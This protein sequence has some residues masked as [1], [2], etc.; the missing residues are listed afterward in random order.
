MALESERQALRDNK[1]DREAR[2]ELLSY[3]VR[4]LQ[5]LSLHPGEVEALEQERLLLTNVG[6]ISAGLNLALERLYDAEVASAH[7]GI[8]T[9]LREVQALAAMDPRLTSAADSL[10]QARI[11]LDDAV[12]QIR[13]RLGSL[14][15]DPARQ[16]EV[17]SRLASAL[18]L[19]RKHRVEPE[20]LP[21]RARD[22]ETELADLDGS[23]S[24]LEA[25]ETE[26]ARLDAALREAAHALH[27]ARNAAAESLAAAVTE[28]LHGLGMP[29]SDFRVRI[30]PLPGGQSTAAGT[31]QVEFLVSTG[32]GQAPG[33]IA[34]VA[35]GGELSRLSL[36]IQV[37]AMTRHG[38]PTLI[39]DEVDAGIGGGVA[40]I[41]GQCL[42][43]LSRGRQ[44]VCVTHLPQVASQADHHFAVTKT[45]AGNATHT[46]VRELAASDRIDEVARMLGGVKITDRTRDH[47]K[48]MLHGARPR[49]AG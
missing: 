25:M 33:P 42:R 46:T 35:S 29:G 32:G 38:P 36:A 37:V 15:H 20:R 4:E 45:A 49:R 6:R 22:L 11:Q 10:D 12:D 39:F 2:Q 1:R 13:R 48:E 40:E 28:N 27:T 34:K 14:E 17:E 21:Q 47:A 24:R 18:E 41:V 3:Q 23:D 9:A 30:E 7:D 5:A 31:D 44:V 19:S 26:S 8:G 16:D 43:Q